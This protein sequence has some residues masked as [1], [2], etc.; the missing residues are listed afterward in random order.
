MGIKRVAIS[1]DYDGCYAIAARSGVVN[2]LSGKKKIF[3]DDP[4]NKALVSSIKSMPKLFRAYLTSITAEADAVS[5][6]V[7]SIRQSYH[8]DKLNADKHKNGSVFPA[9]K[10]LCRSRNSTACQ[11]KFEPFLL[12]DGEEPRGTALQRIQSGAGPHRHNRYQEQRT[13]LGK[14]SKV[15]LLLAQMWDFAR[16]YPDDELEFHFIDD[17]IDILTDVLDN[18]NPKS[19]PLGMTLKLSRFDYRA[20]AEFDSTA[21][22]PFGKIVSSIRADVAATSVETAKFSAVTAKKTNT[23]Y[24][25]R[26]SRSTFFSPSVKD[27]AAMLFQDALCAQRGSAPGAGGLK[28]KRGI[29]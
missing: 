26:S 11:W 27:T 8:S 20:F 5:V 23:V 16:Q 12:A 24:L 9:L 10:G 19:M 29:A 15:P 7:G 17:N 28:R 18:L 22:G 2:E 25:L 6:Y 13:K 21:M 3:Y 14:S 4:R 1:Q